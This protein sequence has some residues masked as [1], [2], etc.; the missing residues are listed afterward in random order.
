MRCTSIP[1]RQ[2]SRRRTRRV[3]IIAF[4]RQNQWKENPADSSFLSS[5][6]ILKAAFGKNGKAKLPPKQPRSKIFPRRRAFPLDGNTSTGD[7]SKIITN[8]QKENI[9]MKKE[10]SHMKTALLVPVYNEQEVLPFLW[11]QLQSVRKSLPQETFE[12]LFVNDGSTDGTLALLKQWAAE[13][14]SIKIISLS[15]NFGK[16]AALTAGLYEAA[17]AD[18]VIILD[19]DLQ[20]PPELIIPFLQKYREGFDVVYGQRSDR[21]RDSFFKRF[22]ARC[23]YKLYNA[24][25]VRPLPENAGDCRLLSRRAVQAVLSLPERERFM[26]GLFNWI[27]F[28]TAAVPF[29]RQ[30]RKAGKTKWNYWRLWNFALEG[31]TASSTVPLRL[32]T[33]FGFIVSGFAFLYALWIAAQKIFWGNPVSGYA[34]LMVTVL[35][36]SGVQLISLGVIG[37]YLGRVFIETK[38]RPL[39]LI[40][41]KTNCD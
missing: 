29:A 1:S 38:Q 8:R 20:D 32:W 28:R 30:K 4:I 17:K 6:R 15:R 13:N 41:E 36:F 25:A 11:E 35:F 19:A 16:E 22:T 3:I 2:K 14:S 37:E 9:I 24:L 5:E 12:Y 18:A 21:R 39:Y 40:D 26:K 31:L 23:F 33:Y 10:V 7:K 34:S 27:G